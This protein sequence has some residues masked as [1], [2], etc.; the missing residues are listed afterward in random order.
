MK[1]I[2]KFDFDNPNIKHYRNI[3]TGAKAVAYISDSE[4][5]V[6][7][8]GSPDFINAGDYIIYTVD[9][10]KGLNKQTFESYFKEDSWI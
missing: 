2:N 7:G 9:I 8:L 4:C 6:N 3:E 10:I 1:E 5:R